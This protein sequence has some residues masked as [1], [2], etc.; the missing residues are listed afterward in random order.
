MW[1]NRLEMPRLMLYFYNKNGQKHKRLSYRFICYATKYNDTLNLIQ[2]TRSINFSRLHFSLESIIV[3]HAGVF[4]APM[5]TMAYPT[6]MMIWWYVQEN[7]NWRRF[8]SETWQS[9]KKQD[10]QCLRVYH[11]AAVGNLSLQG[12]PDIEQFAIIH[13]MDLQC[14][15]VKLSL[16][17]TFTFFPQ[18]II[19]IDLKTKRC[20]NEWC[21]ASNVYVVLRS[22]RKEIYRQ[23][24]YPELV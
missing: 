9:T 20:W 7:N 4:R 2:C 15:D 3:A 18:A 14:T 24:G 17:T 5:S 22:S 1:I 8:D 21:N 13:F 10:F 12:Y 19:Y 6:S 11:V 23:R 16:R